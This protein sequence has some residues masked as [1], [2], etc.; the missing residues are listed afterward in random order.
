MSCERCFPMSKE[1]PTAGVY[2]E[3]EIEPFVSGIYF[4]EEDFNVEEHH[5]LHYFRES[6]RHVV[7]ELVRRQD[8]KNR[9]QEFV[10]FL[11]EKAP[12][13]ENGEAMAEIINKFHQIK[14]DNEQKNAKADCGGCGESFDTVEEAKNCDCKNLDLENA[15]G[16]DS[17]L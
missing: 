13:I 15:E 10:R 11:Y 7:N 12:K 8:V 9:D 14:E 16:D 4:S 17:E 1:L 5:D 6:E 2:V 3:N